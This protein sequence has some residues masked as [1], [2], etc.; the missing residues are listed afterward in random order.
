MPIKTFS[1]LRESERRLFGAHSSC[2]CFYH[3]PT[4]TEKCK[5]S[6]STESEKL[7]NIIKHRRT[8]PVPDNKHVDIYGCEIEACE[9]PTHYCESC[10]GGRDGKMRMHVC[11]RPRCE[12]F[13]LS[14]GD[15]YRALTHYHSLRIGSHEEKMVETASHL[16]VPLF[17]IQEAFSFIHV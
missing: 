8:T 15:L 16:N 9:D 12:G 11:N 4:M 17:D 2:V 13:Q 10:I 5:V 6:V 1:V 14:S 3:N 7:V